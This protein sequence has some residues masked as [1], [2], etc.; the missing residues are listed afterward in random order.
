MRSTFPTFS[1]G[2]DK[3]IPTP[4][5]QLLIIGMVLA[6][7]F[8]GIGV[9]SAGN[10]T[11]AN[12]SVPVQSPDITAV[13]PSQPLD[14]ITAVTTQTQA[15]I[16]ALTTPVP[17]KTIPATTDNIES[18]MTLPIS[19][20]ITPQ[21]GS[22]AVNSVDYSSLMK[23]GAANSQFTMRA[24]KR[25]TQEEKDAAAAR[26]K[27]VREAF[28]V[29]GTSAKVSQ[30]GFSIAEAIPPTPVTFNSSRPAM[31]P[32]G[33]PHY[34]GPYPNWV[35]S[36]MPMG[37]IS[38]ITVDSGGSG[39]SNPVI[40]IADVYFTGSGATATATLGTVNG[41]SGV[42][43][44]ITVT[45]GGINYTAPVV[46]ING[47]TGADAAATATL[48]GPYTSGLRKFVDTLPGLNSANNLGNSIPT[49]IADTA[50]FTTPPSDYYEI[51]VLEF[52][53]KMHSDLPETPLR[54]YVQI[55]TPFI[56]GSDHYPLV[57]PNGTRIT[58][59][60]GIPMFGVHKPQ[61]LGPII[62]ATKDKPVRV[63]FYNFLPIGAGGN[64]FLPVDTTVMGAGMGPQAMNTSPIFYTQNRAELHLH[65]GA[66]PWIS[67]G[68]PY[69]WITPAGEYTTYDRGVSVYNV[70]DMPDPGDGA[71][72]YYYTNQQ[73]ARLMFYHDHAHGITRLNVYAGEAA[74]YVVTDDI[75]QNLISGGVA[76]S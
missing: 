10:L 24:G 43:T 22:P 76:T 62:V 8:L 21:T 75:E 64:L 55:E 44:G 49:A 16:T 33:I 68:T 73:S 15:F 60:V 20:T 38:A 65:G 4:R 32:G 52:S 58:N 1:K 71:Q 50:S 9:V 18:V 41:V 40:T 67:D 11:D 51:A 47:A 13:P 3:R 6:L 42:I 25:V 12:A 57:Y 17:V 39:Y 30:G 7:F 48:G 56:T 74:G 53:E 70:P 54:A 27:K 28:L 26:Y 59:S 2:S 31:D 63:K 46:I 61:Y 19:P 36:P 34:F 45:N 14:V 69:Q 35:N 66:T 23:V 29:Q 72:T 5:I 37:N